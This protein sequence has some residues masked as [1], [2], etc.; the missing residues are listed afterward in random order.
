MKISLFILKKKKTHFLNILYY[1]VCFRFIFSVK[2]I[3]S[4]NYSI[5]SYGLTRGWVV[6]AP[7]Q[8]VHYFMPCVALSYQLCICLN[9]LILIPPLR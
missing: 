2:T 7:S 6:G 3:P 4:I 1:A 5:L 8:I 9:A